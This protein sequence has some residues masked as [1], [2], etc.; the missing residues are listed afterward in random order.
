MMYKYYYSTL[1]DLNSPIQL[2]LPSYPV[3]VNDYYTLTNKIKLQVPYKCK[4]IFKHNEIYNVKRRLYR[5]ISVGLYI[6]VWLL[7]DTIT[8]N[9]TAALNSAEH[10]GGGG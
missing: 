10:P 2:E 1:H 7:T 3:I 4:R 6:H 8:L 5:I 9:Q